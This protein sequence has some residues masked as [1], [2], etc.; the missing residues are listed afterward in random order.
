[1]LKYWNYNKNEGKGSK[2]FTM[3]GKWTQAEE[4]LVREL[5]AKSTEKRINWK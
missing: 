3:T 1:M 4:D 5:V 2:L